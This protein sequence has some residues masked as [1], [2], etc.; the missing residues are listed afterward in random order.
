MK[1]ICL[2][3][4]GLLSLTIIISAQE[5]G[6]QFQN[7]ANWQEVLDKARRENKYIFVDCYATWCGPCKYMDKTIFPEKEVGQFFNEKFISVKVQMDKTKNDAAY[8]QSWYPDAAR[9]E[10]EYFVTAFPTYLFFSPAGEVLHRFSATTK[11]GAEFIAKAKHAFDPARQYYTN[12][13]RYKEHLNDSAFLRNSISVALNN[14]DR[15]MAEE[16]GNHYLNIVNPLRK[17]NLLIIRQV[18]FSGKDRGFDILM[19]NTKKADSIMGDGFAAMVVRTVMYT[20]DLKKYIESDKEIKNWNRFAKKLKKK[21]HVVDPMQI[22][23]YEAHYYRGKNNIAAFEKALVAFMEKYEGRFND[24]PYN[25][26]AWALFKLSDN[27]EVLEIALKWSE[28]S[29]EMVDKKP[30]GNYPNYL[31]TYSSLLYKLG[32]KN[33]AILW[34]NKAIAEAEIKANEKLLAALKKTLVKMENGEKTW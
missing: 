20:D 18:T 19:K 10:S 32:K 30:G 3:V 13:V 22:D 12:V 16:I 14:S 29:I 17:D 1:K 7:A 25:E 24:V 33:E 26:N 34:Q 21:Y 31:D 27:R 6:V 2:I 23:A 5:T 4:L 9:L 15:K 28:R 8:I 11:T